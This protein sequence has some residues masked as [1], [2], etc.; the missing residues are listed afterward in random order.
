MARLRALI[1]VS[2]PLTQDGIRWTQC[3]FSKHLSRTTSSWI[4]CVGRLRGLLCVCRTLTCGLL[5]GAV[6]GSPRE[7]IRGCV[8]MRQLKSLSLNRLQDS[9]L[10]SGQIYSMGCTDNCVKGMTL[11]PFVFFL[12]RNQWNVLSLG[13]VRIC[14]YQG[15]MCI[16]EMLAEFEEPHLIERHLKKRQN[17]RLNKAIILSA[18]VCLE[19]KRWLSLDFPV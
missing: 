8:G 19:K 15:T 16:L 10:N 2:R 18:G 17:D 12:H 6:M 14:M 7:D 11:N 1:D 13:L 4:F 3:E 9:W 5:V